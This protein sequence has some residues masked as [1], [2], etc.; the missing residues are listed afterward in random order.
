MDSSRQNPGSHREM[1]D[2]LDTI[3]IGAE[4]GTAGKRKRPAHLVNRDVWIAV[5]DHLEQRGEFFRAPQPY[6]MDKVDHRLIRLAIGDPSLAHLLRE[7]GLLPLESH[8]L[9]V[10][11][12]L[13]DLGNNAPVRPVHRFA[14]YGESALYVRASDTRMIKVTSQNIEEAPLGT[15]SVILIADDLGDWPALADLTQDMDRLRSAVGTACT[16]LLPGLPMHKLTTRWATTAVLSAE[17]QHQLAFSRFLFMLAASRYSTWALLLLTGDGNSGKTT[18]LEL[19]LALLTGDKPYVK[20]FPGVERDLQASVTNSTIV[21]YD[22]IDG[23]GLNRPEKSSAND[24]ICHLAT[25]AQIDLRVLYSDNRLARY[26]VQTHAFFT[27]RVNEF[28]RQDVMRR[29]IELEMA[30]PLSDGENIDRD[31]LIKKVLSDRTAMLAEMLLRAQ[32]IVR[33]HEKHAGDSFRY[34]SRMAEYERFTLVCAA[35]EGTLTE[36]K[37]IWSG[38]MSQYERSITESNPLVF[39]IRLWLGRGANAGR[40]IAPAALFAEL[41]NVYR[42]LEQTFPYKSAAAFGKKINKNLPSL[43]AIGFSS[44]P[45]RNGQN[46]VFTPSEQELA[47]CTNQYQD[48]ATAIA[49]RP[50]VPCVARTT[51][52]VPTMP[53]ANRQDAMEKARREEEVMQEAISYDFVD[54]SKEI[55]Q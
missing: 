11:Q 44:I 1:R 23:A 53:S 40:E 21:A 34:Q 10:S 8:T 35:Y 33:A 38:V 16:G 30:P 17:Q 45:T 22:N 3:R 19:L 2:L 50:I 51:H 32:N 43:R 36:T 29:T 42:D 39:G 12:A 4:H 49:R 54:H 18:V 13:I 14:F 27:T 52:H 47:G 41:Q 31:E 25:G 46:Y 55:F 9:M 48:L 24:L 37:A 6:Y 15:D 20:R 26:R 5:L 28:D 7:L